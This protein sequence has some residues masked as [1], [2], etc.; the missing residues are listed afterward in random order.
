MT[1]KAELE[2]STIKF[3]GLFLD[4]NLNWVTHLTGLTDK[5]FSTLFA[6]RKLTQAATY[7]AATT[8]YFAI[9]KLHI[10]YD[11][12]LCGMKETQR[13]ILIST[14]KSCIR[15]LY[16]LLLSVCMLGVIVYVSSNRNE[17]LGFRIV[18][19][20]MLV[21]CSRPFIYNV[22]KYMMK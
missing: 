10:G 13:R 11:I 20:Q 1:A 17:N 9:V 16:K 4:L 2:S 6:L 19:A 7:T 8:D 12:T 18:K 15:I 14:K 22:H 3:L 21:N 5:L